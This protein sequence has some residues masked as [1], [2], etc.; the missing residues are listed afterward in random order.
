MSL[1]ACVPRALF[2]SLFGWIVALAVSMPFQI[3]EAVRVSGRASSLILAL[4]LW[5]VITFAASLYFC[6]F[7]FIPVAWLVPPGWIV[8][9]RW[10]WISGSAGFGIVLTA[11][12][13]HI[14]TA[15]D[16]D[17]VSLMNFYVWSVFTA[18]FLGT[19]A[20]RYADF[21]S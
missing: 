1:R 14:W 4:L 3:T 20:V 6:I 21:S 19:T 15:L 16:H 11:V 12:R 13:L 9:R 5:L 10:L 17:G 18:A 7:F 2:A 8:R